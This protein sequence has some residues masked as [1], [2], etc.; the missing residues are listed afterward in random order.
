MA[1]LVTP[2]RSNE[3]SQSNQTR[4]QRFGPVY[5]IRLI[6]NNSPIHYLIGIDRLD[7]LWT[8]SYMSAT[9]CII[10]S[11]ARMRAK[12]AQR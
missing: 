1:A 4:L 10:P 6:P 12:E 9:S 11:R 7:C 8:F 2:N 3:A 5:S